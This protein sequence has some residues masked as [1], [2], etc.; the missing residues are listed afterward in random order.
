MGVLIRR[1]SRGGRMITPGTNVGE[2]I[3]CTPLFD[4]IAC[5][6]IRHPYGPRGVRFSIPWVPFRDDCVTIGFTIWI[7]ATTQETS[8]ASKTIGTLENDFHLSYRRLLLMPSFEFVMLLLESQD[9]GGEVLDGAERG[10]PGGSRP[11]PDQGRT[12]GNL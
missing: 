2:P 1:R 5:I 8:K 3:F 9:T 12:N 7:K 6:W 11:T 4:P 10:A